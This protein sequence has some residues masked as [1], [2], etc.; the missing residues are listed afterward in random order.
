[1]AASFEGAEVRP[2]VVLPVSVGIVRLP[3]PA[4]SAHAVE[5]V[6]CA[7]LQ[8][9]MGFFAGSIVLGDV[10]RAS[11]LDLIGEVAAACAAKS[12]HDV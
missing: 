9:I 1:M 10:A 2:L 5:I 7:P 12:A 11:R 4:V 8:F 3:A 6:L